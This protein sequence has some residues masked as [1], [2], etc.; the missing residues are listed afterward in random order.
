MIDWLPEYAKITAVLFAIIMAHR[1][2]SWLVEDS[3]DIIEL[4]T[5]QAQVLSINERIT[6][7][8]MIGMFLGSPSGSYRNDINKVGVEFSIGKQIFLEDLELNHAQLAYYR[9]DNQIPIDL[10]VQTDNGW[11]PSYMSIR[12]LGSYIGRV[13]LSDGLAETLIHSIRNPPDEQSPIKEKN[14]HVDAGTCTDCYHKRQ[15][16]PGASL[17]IRRDHSEDLENSAPNS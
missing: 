8:Q 3:K 12:I 13:N 17:D 6:E 7:G 14:D 1:G 5:I 10:K 15:W 2:V 11:N 4:T 9:K 16:K